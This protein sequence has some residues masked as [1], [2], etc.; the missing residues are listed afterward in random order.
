MRVSDLIGSHKE[1]SFNSKEDLG[2]ALY[3]REKQVR[4]VGV[5]DARGKI[6]WPRL[7]ERYFGYCCRRV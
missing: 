6:G 7:A 5:V 2:A 1:V 4:S 3:L